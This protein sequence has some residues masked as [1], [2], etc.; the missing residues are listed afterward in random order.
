MAIS[1]LVCG[2]AVGFLGLGM[3]IGVLIAGGSGADAPQARTT[4]STAS[5]KRET[6]AAGEPA[7]RKVT[8]ST[9]QA[10]A[11]AKANRPTTK[12]SVSVLPSPVPPTS[13]QS[14]AVATAAIRCPAP[15][16][17]VETA[18]ELQQALGLVGPGE[19]IQ[20]ADGVYEGNFVATGV[21]TE[22]EPIFLCGS[23][24]AILDGGDPSDGYVLHLDG[25][26]WWRVVGFTVRNG[27]KGVMLDGSSNSILQRMTVEDI[28]DEG[29]HLRAG[30]SDNQ[31]LDNTVRRT[32]L[33]KQQYGEGIYVGT[34]K[35]NWGEY[36]AGQ[37]DQSDRNV[38]SGNTISETGAE[39]VDVKE[40]TTGGTLV[41][42]VMD[43]SG[44]TG[45]DSLVDIKGNEWVIQGNTGRNGPV[46]GFQ[47]HRILDGW[48]QH[49][50]FT[51]NNVAVAGDGWHV[52]INDPDDTG[53]TVSCDN[54]TVDGAPLRTNLGCMP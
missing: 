14:V 26:Q 54:T 28:G 50:V 46:D 11:K 10:E 13:P 20:L 5:T 29:V 19:S 12:P 47:T 48:G 3:L 8:L 44:M 36:S 30:S 7:S 41:G 31:V 27:Q 6:R 34:A 53:N 1:R 52:Y 4:A 33:R 18:D 39:S 42:N 43:G 15:T 51:G 40:G 32:G 2:V 37:P 16:V 9:S 49:N 24:A 23:P 22:A 35:S 21:G 38:I 25:A 45:A 17:R